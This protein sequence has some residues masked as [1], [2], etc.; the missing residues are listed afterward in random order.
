VRLDDEVVADDQ[1]WPRLAE[2]STTSELLDAW[3][4][5]E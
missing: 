5:G 2:A 3:Q 1:L 4:R